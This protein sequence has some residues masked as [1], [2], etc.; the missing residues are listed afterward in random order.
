MTRIVLGLIALFFLSTGCVT[1]SRQYEGTTL[2]ADKLPALEIGKTTQQDVLEAFG[3]P[4]VLQRRD[5]EGLL[6]SLGSRFRGEALTL[7]VDPSLVNDVYIYEYRRVNR[8]AVI[9]FFFNYLTSDEKSD[10]LMFFFETD[11]TLGG[12]G[13]TEGTEEL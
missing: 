3:P 2:P 12:Y 4:K 7:N 1:I 13:I 10:R 8:T 5:F 11:G 9:L 6:R